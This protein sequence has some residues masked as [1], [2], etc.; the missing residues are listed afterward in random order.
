M[1]KVNRGVY[2]GP[3]HPVIEETR[4]GCERV[5]SRGGYEVP[6]KG[7]RENRTHQ[8]PCQ[9]RLKKLQTWRV[10]MLHLA[11]VTSL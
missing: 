7:E 4:N 11:E 2:S 6:G 9:R 8:E 1:V 3:L 5:D 10:K